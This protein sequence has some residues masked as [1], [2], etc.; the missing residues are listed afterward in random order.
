MD[1][2]L[3]PLLVGFLLLG[4]TA[5]TATPLSNVTNLNVSWPSCAVAGGSVMCWGNAT[6][7]VGPVDKGFPPNMQ[8]VIS[9]GFGICALNAAGGVICHQNATSYDMGLDSGVRALRGGSGSSMCAMMSAGGVKCW[10]DNRYAQLGN[11]TDESF[12]GYLR[13]ADVTVLSDIAT[14]MPGDH[15]TCAV[16]LAGAAK[17]W[18]TNFNGELGNG[19][20]QF[21]TQL[22]PSDVV[23]LGSGVADIEV[24]DS[25]TCALTVAGGVKCWGRN[26][27]GQVGNGTTLAYPGVTAPADV[28]GLASGVVSVKVGSNHACALTSSG[29][30]KCWGM[31]WEGQLGDGTTVSRTTP[32]DVSGLPAGVTAI[33]A[34][35]DFSCA[36][37]NVGEV[38]CWGSNFNGQLGGNVSGPPQPI[39]ARVGVFTPQ[40]I[41]FP[42]LPNGA[43]G[44]QPFAPVATASS[45]LPVSFS[46]TTPNVCTVASGLVSLNAIGLCTIAADQPGDSEYLRAAQV[47]RTF[48][49]QGGESIRLANISTRVSVQQGEGMAIGGFVIGG[50][51]PKTVLI[52]ALGPS[53]ASFGVGNA[54]ADPRL[55]IYDGQT[56]IF[57]N[58]NWQ[59]MSNAAVVQSIGL[60]PGDARESAILVTLKQGAYT[61]IV[62]G[63]NGTTGVGLIEVYEIDREDIPLINISTRG[64][65]GTGADVMIGGFVITGNAPQ[66]VAITAKGPSLANYGIANP[67]ADPTLTLVRSS[68]QAVVATNDDWAT[69]PR[70][71]QLQLTG[72]AP[73]HNKE[74]ALLVTLQPGAYTAVVSGVGGGTGVGLVEVYA[75]P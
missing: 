20:V 21:Q 2:V 65:V 5:A 58:D 36:L 7:P 37:T 49:V 73:F 4:G 15:H 69:D 8:S 26:E 9:N 52:R 33:G 74:A 27:S 39:P 75:V 63:A 64:V 43:L 11:G 19:S 29:T 60:A 50:L 53:L 16:T 68:D 72:F 31:N 30:V 48:L 54:L 38:W 42:A 25:S 71:G 32:V 41:T 56:Q 6:P 57:A 44:G 47:T 59:G 18:G 62:S 40:A 55:S 66:T 22:T 23:G 13:P 3:S 70:A 17:C 12:S 35:Y 45:G 28:V 51:A 1:R 10:G 46:S 67:L 14:M 61:A 24:G 34:G